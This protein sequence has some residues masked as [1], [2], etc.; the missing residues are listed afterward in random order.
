MNSIRRALQ[1]SRNKP[2]VQGHS[3]KQQ[4]TIGS[5]VYTVSYGYGL[6]E[7]LTSETYS[8]GWILSFGFDNQSNTFVDNFSY[9]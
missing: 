4:E 1:I 5:T 6:A 2:R 8:S 9:A 3:A 7:Q